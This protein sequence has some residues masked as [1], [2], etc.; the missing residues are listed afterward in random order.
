MHDAGYSCKQ[1]YTSSPSP[2][3]TGTFSHSIENGENCKWNPIFGKMSLFINDGFYVRLTVW[4]HH[5]QL[6]LQ[7]CIFIYKIRFCI[8][9]VESNNKIA[10]IILNV[11]PNHVFPC[12]LKLNT[13]ITLAFVEAFPVSYKWWWVYVQ[14]YIIES[15]NVS[16]WFAFNL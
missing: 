13:E 15:I 5:I 1:R 6:T 8:F 10:L 14:L 11:I 16:F 4:W 7:I 2:H 9:I 12:K 3:R